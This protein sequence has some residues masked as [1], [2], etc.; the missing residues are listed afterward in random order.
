M[1]VSSLTS[2]FLVLPVFDSSASDSPKVTE[3]KFY[4]K[5]WFISVILL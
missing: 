5:F 3:R 2:L 1:T 4:S